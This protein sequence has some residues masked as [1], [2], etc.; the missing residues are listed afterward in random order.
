MTILKWKNHPGLFNLIDDME[1]GFFP[2]ARRNKCLEPKVNILETEKAF[3]IQVAVPGIK[4][5]DINLLVEKNVLTVSCEIKDPEETQK[6]EFIKQEF[7]SESFSRSFSIPESVNPE[8]ISAQHKNGILGVVLQKKE[9]EKAMLSK[10][11][12]IL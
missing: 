4:K 5:E 2:E 11:I 12:K 10:S 9:E 7:I 1:R 8:K 6:G 3:E